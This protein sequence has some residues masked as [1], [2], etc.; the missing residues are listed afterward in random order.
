MAPP[1]ALCHFPS[2]WL[3]SAKAP[4]QG[5]LVHQRLGLPARAHSRAHGKQVS[6]HCRSP[7]RHFLRTTKSLSEVEE[8][9]GSKRRQETEDWGRK[10]RRIHVCR[11]FQNLSVTAR[12]AALSPSH[13]RRQL[14]ATPINMDPF[15]K[16][17]GNVCKQPDPIFPDSREGQP[18]SAAKLSSDHPRNKSKEGKW[19]MVKVTEETS[20][21]SPG[22]LPG[23]AHEGEQPGPPE[24]PNVEGPVPGILP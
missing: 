15:I 1:P 11:N 23:K 4:G 9:R 21:R 3:A 18:C 8:E 24:A 10:K 2:P 22:G 6:S 13:P 17:P 5:T 19:Y 7:Q 16:W 12:Q 14:L 20:Q